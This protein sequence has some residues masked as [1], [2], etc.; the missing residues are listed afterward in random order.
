MNLHHPLTYIKGVSANRA[1]LLASE[2][3]LNRLHDLLH[4]FPFRYIDK[5][6]FYKIAELLN[7]N[8]E[9]QIIGRI[10][11][12]TQVK[13]N[14]GSRLVAKFQDETGILELVWFKGHQ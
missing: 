9:V 10:I 14:R 12:M 5:T 11:S 4:F 8:A 2:L 7:N 1:S 13:Q 6:R 3:G